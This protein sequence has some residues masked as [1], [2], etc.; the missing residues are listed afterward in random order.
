MGEEIDRRE[1]EK[2]DD[3]RFW[4]QLIR[5]PAGTTSDVS[6]AYDKTEHFRISDTNGKGRKYLYKFRTDPR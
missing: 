2:F 4:S 1:D 3:A 6:P 5:A